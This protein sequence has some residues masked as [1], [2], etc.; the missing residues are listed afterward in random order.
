MMSR[1]RM[2]DRTNAVKALE[3][4]VGG[5]FSGSLNEC[6]KEKVEGLTAAQ[7][8]GVDQS[9]GVFFSTLPES[10]VLVHRGSWVE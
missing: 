5:F 4:N 3:T 9:S 10:L 8:P 7:E 1:S 2:G 6:C